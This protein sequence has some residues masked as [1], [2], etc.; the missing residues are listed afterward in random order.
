MHEIE[1]E[2]PAEFPVVGARVICGGVDR[3]ADFTGAHRLRRQAGRIVAFKRNDIGGR[4]VVEKLSMQLRE[5]WIGQ[6]DERQFAVR[7]AAGWDADRRV[8]RIEDMNQVFDR[9]ALQPK[10]GVPVGDV[11]TARKRRVGEGR[12]SSCAR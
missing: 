11:D 9:A 5:C 7:D 1:R 4:R 8:I 10:T 3:N 12:R 2:F 6:E